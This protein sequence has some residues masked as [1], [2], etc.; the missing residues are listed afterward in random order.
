MSF[1]FLTKH[2]K[3]LIVIVENAQFNNFSGFP[4][5]RLT[6]TQSVRGEGREDPSMVFKLV[7]FF[8]FNVPANYLKVLDG[9]YMDDV[10][11][12]APFKLFVTK[13][14]SGWQLDVVNVSNNYVKFPFK[15]TK[16]DKMKCNHRL[17]FYSLLTLLIWPF[18]HCFQ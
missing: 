5:A 12:Q 3:R 10:V 2:G 11:F 4:C 1:R 6:R 9:V 15:W 8:F 7:S 14:T 16:Y 17:Q 18:Q 13:V